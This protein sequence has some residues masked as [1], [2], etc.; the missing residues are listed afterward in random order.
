LQQSVT[1]LGGRHD[2]AFLCQR[3]LESSFV[4]TGGIVCLILLRHGYIDI[5]LC[6]LP[7]HTLS[8]I[9]FFSS[10][11]I[12]YILSKM[13]LDIISKVVLII[14]TWSV[15]IYLLVLPIWYHLHL[16]TT[17]YILSRYDTNDMWFEG[18]HM[19]LNDIF[20]IESIWY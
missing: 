18:A 5:V 11:L 6:R 9:S 1:H 3:N 16:S 7:V 19:I 10:I 13:V 2:R 12:I 4:L 20:L 17:R 8:F 15:I 14:M